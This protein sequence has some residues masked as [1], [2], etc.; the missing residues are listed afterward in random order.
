MTS[1]KLGNFKKINETQL[2]A[3]RFI[4]ENRN[5]E[6]GDSEC[7]CE[8]CF[9]KFENVSQLFRHISHTKVC[10][11]N[12]GQVYIDAMRK[13]LRNQSKR[14]W[15]EA[16]KESLT[17]SRS[18]KNNYIPNS[19][20]LTDHGRKFCDVFRKV[21]CKHQSV[22]IGHIEEYAANLCNFV[23]DE[24]IDEALDLAFSDIFILHLDCMKESEDEEENLNVFFSHI[25][26][27]F[28]IKLMIRNGS[29]NWKKRKSNLVGIELWRYASNQA[30]LKFYD[31]NQFKDMLD[32]ATDFALD[33]IFL[34]LIT[35]DQYFEDE[36]CLSNKE[37]KIKLES[38]FNQ[39]VKDE[40][41]KKSIE[42][43][44][45]PKLNQLME[46]IMKKRV[47]LDEL[48]HLCPKY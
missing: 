10:S 47:Y 3:V 16:N 24:Q 12:Y 40:M 43:D 29:Y 35:T 41:E 8:Y 23:T 7:S 33:E 4:N 28:R 42:I 9:K 17:T 36:E 20:R 18:S 21:F 46:E 25:E 11:E 48:E 34:K 15:F 31:E 5:N 2:S 39:I 19:V 37:L 38:T 6:S 27:I 14:K 22:A 13:E 32:C 45:I 26:K 30:F 44:I 1:S